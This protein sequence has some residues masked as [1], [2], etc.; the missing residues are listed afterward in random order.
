MFTKIQHIGYR[1]K[2]LDCAVAW[3]AEKFGGQ[4]AAGGPAQLGGRNAFVRF[5][6]I[7][8]ELL[9][10][11]GH[12]ELPPDTL[13]MHHVGYVVPDVRAAATALKKK[14]LMFTADEPA[15]NPLSHQVLW[16]DP[17]TTNDILIHL[18]QL[19]ERPNTV[20]I[21]QGLEI[22]RIIHAGYIVDD[23]DEAVA[24]Y[25]DK[26][27]GE[28]IGGG[29]SRRGVN[30]AF[31][32]FGQVQVE[33]LEPTDPAQLGGKKQAMDHVG[34]V[35]KDIV[36]GIRACQHRGLKLGEAGPRYNTISQQLCYFDTACTWGTQIHLTQLPD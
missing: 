14:G 27:G 12:E 20:G 19:P 18:T 16:L 2:D 29:M 10:P 1:V 13:L 32:N 21:G 22:D 34:Y 36:A 23:L 15:V 35:V 25:V 3:F 5:G 30:N 7:E 26:F 24:W 6:Q 17:A 33:L 8:V 31:V 4:R 9:E 11:L 28:Y